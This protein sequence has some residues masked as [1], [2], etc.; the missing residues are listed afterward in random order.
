MVAAFERAHQER[1]VDWLFAYAQSDHILASAIQTIR[2]RYGVPCVN[3]SLDDKQSWDLGMVGEQRRGSIGLVA[4]FDLWWTSA[5]VS[6]DWVNA[7][8]GRAIYLPE[9][10]APSIYHPAGQPFDI[11]VSFVGACY[12]PRPTMVQF[13][14]EYGVPVQVFGGGWKA[15]G[16]AAWAETRWTYSGEAR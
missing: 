12:G 16:G 6:V 8:G 1:P 15:M 14:R 3:M 4:A 5:R 11:P 9:G 10:C 7:E 13:L 2:E